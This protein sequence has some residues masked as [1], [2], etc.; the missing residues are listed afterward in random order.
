MKSYE[1]YLSSSKRTARE[2]YGIT[3]PTFFDSEEIKSKEIKTVLNSIWIVITKI[4][5]SIILL[6]Q[7]RNSILY[8]NIEVCVLQT[9]NKRSL[10]IN[11]LHGF[12]IDKQIYGIDSFVRNNECSYSD[13][14]L[15]LKKTILNSLV[16]KN[17][18]DFSR[19]NNSKVRIVHSHDTS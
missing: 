3:Y 17:S 2:N 9:T 10:E 18:F 12:H 15:L 1:A 6:V 11:E 19:N 16:I 14:S 4:Y 5:S 13:F 7:K 8:S